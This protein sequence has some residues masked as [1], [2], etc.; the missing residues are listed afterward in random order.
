M[1]W[2]NSGDTISQQVRY[3]MEGKEEKRRKKRKIKHQPHN[4]KTKQLFQEK[5]HTKSCVK[6]EKNFFR[7][8]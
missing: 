7:V 1:Q 5:K 8:W 2:R 6:A 4:K 3:Q